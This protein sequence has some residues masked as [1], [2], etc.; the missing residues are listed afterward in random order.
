[1]FLK[2]TDTEQSNTAKPASNLIG[3]KSFNYIDKA[4]ILKENINKN[5]SSDENTQS[6]KQTESLA[7]IKSKFE[8]NKINQDQSKF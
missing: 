8:S 5:N 6:I 2:S 3:T 4:S 7:A 1:M